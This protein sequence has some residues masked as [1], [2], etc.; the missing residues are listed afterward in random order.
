MVSLFVPSGTSEFKKLDREAFGIWNGNPSYKQRA[1]D[2]PAIKVLVDPFIEGARNGSGNCFNALARMA[3]DVDLI[4]YYIVSNKSFS[5]VAHRGNVLYHE[6]ANTSLWAANKAHQNGD[7]N[8]QDRHGETLA[9]IK[10]K[11][12]RDYD[13]RYNNALRRGQ[14]EG[15]YE[16]MGPLP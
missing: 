10:R 9:D 7:R 16:A 8:V 13:R 5:D 14:V 6:V 4:A 11:K 15:K 1:V 12:Q 3:R 2:Y